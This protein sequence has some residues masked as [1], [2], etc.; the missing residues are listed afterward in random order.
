MGQPLFLR[1]GQRS[2]RN[3]F[4]RPHF[5]SANG[6]VLEG[7]WSE[8]VH[9]KLC[10]GVASFTEMKRN[11]GDCDALATHHRKS[12]GIFEKVNEVT[13]SRPIKTNSS[14]NGRGR[15]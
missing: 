6:N 9:A 3:D 7:M 5:Q 15:N 13:V 2:A 8:Y 11:S 4:F 12:A 14:P 10:I 1:G